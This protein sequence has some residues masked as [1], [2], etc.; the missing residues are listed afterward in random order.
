MTG[1]RDDGSAIVEV[2]FLGVLLLIPLAYALL[3]AFE[4]QRAAYALTAATRDAGRAYVQ[5]DTQAQARDR[6]ESA[7]RLVV[8][9][10]GLAGNRVDVSFE[11]E[12]AGCLAP[13][14]TVTVVASTRVPLP[15]LPSFVDGPASIAVRAEHA[16]VVDR[17]RADRS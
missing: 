8:E 3:A 10:H 15:W 9:G 14:S 13:G 7:A 6:G 11:C 1:R 2:T 5:A 12:R 17:F 4:V 16:A